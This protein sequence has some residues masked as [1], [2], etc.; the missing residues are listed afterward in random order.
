MT[1]DYIETVVNNY[2]NTIV[3]NYYETSPTPTDTPSP[4][5]T[6]APTS[7]PTDTPPTEAP[8]EQPPT[9]TPS[10]HEEVPPGY[11]E[12]LLDAL[13]ALTANQA[14]INDNITTL[15]DNFRRYADGIATAVTSA[16][17]SINAN[18][19]YNALLV[20]TDISQ[21]KGSVIALK[22]GIASDFAAQNQ[23]LDN[24]GAVID[25]MSG[26]MSEKLDGLS[27]L[28]T[29]NAEKEQLLLNNLSVLSQTLLAILLLFLIFKVFGAVTWR[30]FAR[31]FT[32]SISFSSPSTTTMK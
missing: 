22:D 9:P 26:T 21:L 27:E 30:T 28:F 18:A 23:R 12:D 5:P 8:T 24:L 32:L 20:R 19:D 29:E 10:P 6:T 4:T 13:N 14:I 16:A 15:D 2:Y 3:N 7:S 11:Y 31:L 1:T 17:G 25:A